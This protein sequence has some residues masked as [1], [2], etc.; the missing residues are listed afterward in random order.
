M[1]RYSVFPLR[2]LS[3]VPAP[4]GTRYQKKTE[5]QK[6]SAGLQGQADIQEKEKWTFHNAKSSRH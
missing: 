4:T 6:L 2:S 5:C 1:D 3:S